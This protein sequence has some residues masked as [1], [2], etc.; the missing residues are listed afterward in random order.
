MNL[1]YLWPG[2]AN[3]APQKV[4]KNIIR[5]IVD[6]KDDVKFNLRLLY[7][8][9]R[10]DK[11]IP[12][13][14]DVITFSEF[15]NLKSSS[16]IHEPRPVAPLL[17]GWDKFQIYLFSVQKK[18]PIVSNYHGNFYMEFVGNIKNRDS[19]N[20]ITC[21]RIFPFE[22]LFFRINHKVIVHSP[23][24]KDIIGR[25]YGS[26]SKISILPNGIE[27]WWFNAKV[28]SI[29]I[30]GEPSIFYH[31]G[32]SYLKGSIFLIKA[33]ANLKKKTKNNAKLYLAGSGPIEKKLKDMCREYGIDKEVIFLGYLNREKLKMYL[34]SCDAAIYPSLFENFPLAY[35]EALSSAKGQCYFSNIGAQGILYF[36]SNEEKKI[37]N[38]FEPTEEG[39]YEVLSGIINC[40]ER[41]NNL[42]QKEFAKNFLWEKVINYY[43]DLYNEI[44]ETI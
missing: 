15:K 32:L 10:L 40:S 18:I 31:G 44:Y 33:F 30:K 26:D 22:L 25:R 36:A 24:M 2:S 20:T 16:I 17:S 35:L 14:L 38:L 12:K 5:C 13:G 11:D 3:A 37:L 1:I 39:I 9:K 6:R 19:L 23:I 21:M 8:E 41:D 29:E 4:G 34:Q 28:S 7:T 27:E 42:K 43:I